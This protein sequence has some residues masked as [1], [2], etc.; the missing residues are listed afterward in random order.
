MPLSVYKKLK[1]GEP[2]STTVTLQLVDRS[3]VYPEGKVENVL[4]KVD[5][6]IL[7]ADFIILD[8]EE[9]REVPIILGRAFLATGGAVIDVKEG[10]LAMNVN[11]EQVKFNIL[12]AMKYPR[13]IE[14]CS[15]M[16]IIDYVVKDKFCM[17][18]H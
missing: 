10:E 13:D 17:S 2:N 7:P 15:R 18:L 6:F 12:K 1:V 9:D 3:L 14:E 4:V 5:K 16:D 11:G 8:Y